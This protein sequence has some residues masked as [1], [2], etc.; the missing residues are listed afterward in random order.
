MIS[1]PIKIGR[2]RHD[3]TL[4]SL[5]HIHKIPSRIKEPTISHMLLVYACLLCYY[6][7]FRPILNLCISKSNVLLSVLFEKFMKKFKI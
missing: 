4:Y 2:E 7:S 3:G 5:L 1:F 6:Y